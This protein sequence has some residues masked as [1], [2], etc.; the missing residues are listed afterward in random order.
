MRICRVIG[1]QH[2]RYDDNGVSMKFPQNA[3]QNSCL[4]L[5]GK[6]VVIKGC[7]NSF[8]LHKKLFMIIHTR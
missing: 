3:N 4:T 7:G 6:F 2:G 1:V 8:E 5:L